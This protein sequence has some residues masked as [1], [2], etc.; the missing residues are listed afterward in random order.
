MAL[1][2]IDEIISFIDS[3]LNEQ[4]TKPKDVGTGSESLFHSQPIIPHLS[5]PN[6]RGTEALEWYSK[7]LSATIIEKAF[8]D[9]NKRI[10]HSVMKMSNDSIVFLCDV[11]HTYNHHIYSAH[12][13]AKEIICIYIIVILFLFS[14][15][16]Y[17]AIPRA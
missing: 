6:G 3:A 13:Q 17:L 7:Y 14:T 5:I 16:C 1:K 8:A 12:I 10:I 11:K 4:N 15:T 9:D 2:L